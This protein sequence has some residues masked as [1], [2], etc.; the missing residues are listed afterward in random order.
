MSYVFFGP[1]LEQAGVHT[2]RGNPGLVLEQCELCLDPVYNGEPVSVACTNLHVFHKRCLDAW[3]ASNR[4][5]DIVSKCPL[6]RQIMNLYAANLTVGQ[7]GNLLDEYSEGVWE[8]VARIRARIATFEDT[9]RD[10][11]KLRER[12]LHMLT[13]ADVE[14]AR[15]EQLLNIQQCEIEIEVVTHMIRSLEHGMDQVSNSY[16]KIIQ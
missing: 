10:E 11:A 13:H 3:K 2:R 14:F 12:S 8:Q 9:L 15:Q 4:S 7:V 1:R 6:C 5:Q 16:P